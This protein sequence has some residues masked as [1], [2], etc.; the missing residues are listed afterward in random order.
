MP[1]CYL[2]SYYLKQ[3][4]FHDLYISVK[5]HSHCANA[6]ANANAFRFRRIGEWVVYPFLTRQTHSHNL[7]TSIDINVTQSTRQTQTRSRSHSVNGTLQ[8]SFVSVVMYARVILLRLKSFI[9]FFTYSY[10]LI[11]L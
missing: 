1:Y 10:I 11:D 5:V 6:N 4:N 3:Y 2:M 9:Y 7:N 8:L